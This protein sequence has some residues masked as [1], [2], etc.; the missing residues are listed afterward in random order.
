[1][2]DESLKLFEVSAKLEFDSD[3]RQW[4]AGAVNRLEESFE[5]LGQVDT[6]DAAPLISVLDMRNVF[7]ED[8]AKKPV[9]REELLSLAPEE[10]DGY[11]QVP[12]TIE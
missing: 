11:F 3:T 6:R 4:A 9:T 2:T 1:M 10:Y 7:R 12:R 8:I 5:K